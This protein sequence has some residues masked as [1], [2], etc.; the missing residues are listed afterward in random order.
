MSTTD[1]DSRF[2]RTAEGWSLGYTADLA[3]SDDHLIV[4]ARVTPNAAD[5]ASLVPMVDE[6]ERRCGTRPEKVTGDSGFFSG[7]A[8][9]EMKRRGIDLYVP[10]NN[11]RNEMHTGKRAHGIGRRAI[12]DPEHLQLREKLRTPQGRQ[13]YRRRQAVVEP[14][15]GVLK[16]QRGMRK[17]QRRGLQA[18]ATEWIM[19]VIAYNLTH[20]AQH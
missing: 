16:Q 7:A 2:L 3:V 6:V 18:V 10:D 8:L 4:G 13:M 1:P 17:F 19:A 5:N 9:H 12:R 15:F 20:M 11:L 14:V